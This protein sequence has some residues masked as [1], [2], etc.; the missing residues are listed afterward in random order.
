M[1][2]SQI[3]RL[4]LSQCKKRIVG[5]GGG[6]AMSKL[7]LNK[8]QHKKDYSNFLK[9]ILRLSSH[10]SSVAIEMLEDEDNQGMFSIHALS[11]FQGSNDR[12]S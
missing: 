1:R 6:P 9:E 2:G 10:P 8:K 7:V 11:A 3:Q 12:I 4:H 5:M